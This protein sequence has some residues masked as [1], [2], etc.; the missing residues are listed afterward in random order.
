M[1]DELRVEKIARSAD[2][3][4]ACYLNQR[5]NSNFISFGVLKAA[6]DPAWEAY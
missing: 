4:K 6:T 2:W 5:L 1:L 3:V